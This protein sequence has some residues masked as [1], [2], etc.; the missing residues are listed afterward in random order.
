MRISN[1]IRG[2]SLLVATLACTALP[3]SAQLANASS[4]TLG[5]AGNA[6]ASARG[7]AALSVNPAG[8]AMPGSASFTL[9]VLPIQ[10]RPGLDP[11]TLKDLKDFGGQV[12]PAATKNE[13]LTRITTAGGESGSGGV[14]VTEIGLALGRFGFQVS[15]L[16]VGNAS[17]S[18]AVAELVLFGNAGKTGSAATLALE[19]SSADAFAMTTA[20]AS[21]AFPLTSAT[22]SMA[23][24]ATFKYTVG[25]AVVVGRNTAGSLSADQVSLDFPVV[26]VDEDDFSPNNGSGVGVDLGF[27]MKNGQLALGAAVLNALNTFKWKEENL[28][29][30][31]GTARLAQGGDSSSDF[32]KRAFAA[33]PASLKALIDDMKFNPILSAGVAYDVSPDFTVSGDVRSRIGDGIAVTPKLHVGAGAEFRGLKALHLRGGAAV[34]TDGIEIGGGA[35]LLLGPVNLSGALASRSGD[36]ASTTVGQVTLSFGGL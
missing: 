21:L 35:S 20:G 23:I 14:D 22:G 10:I 8:L 2:A 36:A 30:R 4:T 9:T 33:A 26:M 29:Y 7:L 32:D 34:I 28:V 27:Q 5:L 12:I 1:C 11:I 17:V 25:H 15:S 18:P 31:P 24:G 19:G 6:T 16:V 3:A 13:W